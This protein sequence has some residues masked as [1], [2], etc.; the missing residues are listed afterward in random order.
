MAHTPPPP[1]G[2]PLLVPLHQ[3]HT[4][5]THFLSPPPLPPSLCAH[6]A[7]GQGRG[8]GWRHG[9]RASRGL[10]R[11]GRR[12]RASGVC[13]WGGG[14]PPTHHCAPH[15]GR[16]SAEGAKSCLQ[17]ACWPYMLL[18]ACRPA[19]LTRTIINTQRCTQPG[20]DAPRAGTQNIG[21]WAQGG[22]GGPQGG[23]GGGGGRYG[24]GAQGQGYGGGRG[25]RGQV[26]AG[27]GV[28]SML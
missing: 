6:S 21:C 13:M 8:G 10:R 7:Q 11:T 20:T 19:Q 9:R 16:T 27:G 24:G 12:R 22:M 17:R 1:F 5:H 14:V 28:R 18:F 3:H 26:R 4:H 15:V 25:G 2:R 23:Y